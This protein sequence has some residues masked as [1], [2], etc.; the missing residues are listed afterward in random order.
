MFVGVFL[1]LIFV[2]FKTVNLKELLGWKNKAWSTKNK[3]GIPCGDEFNLKEA[4]GWRAFFVFIL[5]SINYQSS[6]KIKL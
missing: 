3:G 6:Y 2:F 4:R 1:S 5:H